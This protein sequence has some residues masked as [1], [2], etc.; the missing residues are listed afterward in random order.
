MYNHNFYILCPLCFPSS[1]F[2]GRKSS[3]FFLCFCHRQTKK[4]T[5]GGMNGVQVTG[6]LFRLLFCFPLGKNPFVFF[7]S[8]GR[9]LGKRLFLPVFFFSIP[10]KGETAFFFFLWKKQRQ[11]NQ[12]KKLWQKQRDLPSFNFFLWFFSSRGRK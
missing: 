9:N 8:E 11:T 5:K 6:T 7:S 2:E 1:L 10:P 3:C 12:R 4:S